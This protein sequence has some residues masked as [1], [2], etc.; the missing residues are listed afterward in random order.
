MAKAVWTDTGNFPLSDPEANSSLHPFAELVPDLIL[1]AVESSGLWCSGHILALNSYENRVYQV[2]IE[3][4]LPVIVKFYRPE[5]WSEAQILEEHRFALSLQDAELPVVAPT[6]INGQTLH[7]YEKFLFAVYPR[8]GG[9]AP[10]LS[11]PDQLLILGRTLGRIHQIGQ[12]EP[13]V[14]RPVL[15]IE[16]FGHQSVEFLTEQFVPDS[17][18]PAY[19]SLCSDLLTQIEEVWQRHPWR[20]IRTHGDCHVGNMLWRDETPFFVDFDDARMAPSVQDLWM[21][22]SGERHEQ[23]AQLSEIIEGY[24]EF[25]DFDF[26]ELQLIESLRTLRMMNYSA[27][28]G[29]R[30][31]DPAFPQSFSWFNSP[32]YWGEHILQLREQLSALQQ[33]AIHLW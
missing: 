7:R 30:W 31:D 23:T 15:D 6:I 10:D 8:R 27:W 24:Q 9:R 20:F 2:G 22:T 28:I 25:A 29:R 21:L 32:R 16:S 13:F 1:K 11:N 3:E 5:R 18:R 4:E 14:A 26:A 17:L 12:I 19:S 33:P